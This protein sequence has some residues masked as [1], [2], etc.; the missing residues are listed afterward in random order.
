MRGVPEVPEPPLA[1][2]TGA[3]M[4]SSAIAVSAASVLRAPN[5][6]TAE[7]LRPATKVWKQRARLENLGTLSRWRK[8]PVRATQRHDGRGGAIPSFGGTPAVPRPPAPRGGER[9]SSA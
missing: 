4:A 7:S 8:L 9:G 1:T 5:P 3:A 6:A 2:A